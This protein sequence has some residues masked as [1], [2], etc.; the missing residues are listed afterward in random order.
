MS[1]A[2]FKTVDRFSAVS[3][4]AIWKGK[5]H[6]PLQAIKLFDSTDGGVI[7]GVLDYSDMETVL[8]PEHMNKPYKTC[9]HAFTA[10]GALFDDMFLYEKEGWPRR[11]EQSN[12]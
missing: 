2:T 8:I 5:G 1:D 3:E 10:L 4:L 12:S 6:N 11:E 7:I 9:S